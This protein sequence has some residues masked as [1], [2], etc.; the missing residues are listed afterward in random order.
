[1]D[2]IKGDEYVAPVIVETKKPTKDKKDGKDKLKDKKKDAW[3]IQNQDV[4]EMD[5]NVE[6]DSDEREFIEYLSWDT[7]SDEED[8]TY[9]D[10]IIEKVNKQ[11]RNGLIL[12]SQGSDGKDEEEKA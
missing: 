11:M 10:E 6:I 3:F 12:D 7:D 9:D 5:K 8:M 1:M 2:I 4:Y